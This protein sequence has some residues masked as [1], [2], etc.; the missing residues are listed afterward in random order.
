MHLDSPRPAA[1]P[2]RLLTLTSGGWVLLAAGGMCATVFIW[3]LL[4]TLPHVP[5]PRGDGIDVATYGFDLSTC[6]VPRERIFASGLPRDSLPVLTDPQAL[7]PAELTALTAELRRGHQGKFLVSGDLVVGVVLHEAAR[8][9]PLRLLRWHQVVNDTLADVPIAVTF[10]PLSDSLVVFERVVADR[11]VEFGDSG[12]VYNAVP[13][14][15]DRGIE[16]ST[17]SLWCPLQLRAVAGRAAAQGATLRPLPAVIMPWGEWQL[18]HP[19]TTVLAPQRSHWRLIGSGWPSV[20][21]PAS[22]P[23]HRRTAGPR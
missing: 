22:N 8:A 16:S 14:L 6:L 21:P 7:T 4:G 18:R 13:L 5:T 11:V 3:W 1:P 10:A 23:V 20:S 2:Q 12:L 19:Q 9:Y 15:Y 17:A